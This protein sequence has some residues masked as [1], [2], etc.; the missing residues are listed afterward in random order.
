MSNEASQGEYVE[1]KIRKIMA[2][3]EQKVG[4]FKMKLFFFLLSSFWCHDCKLV[5]QESL[6]A[7]YQKNN[8]FWNAHVIVTVA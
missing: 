8:E 2:T 6:R 1:E 4:R 7:K 3:G 5:Q